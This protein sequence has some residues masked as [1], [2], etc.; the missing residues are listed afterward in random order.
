M[1]AVV[2]RVASAFAE[3]VWALV[4]TVPAG[5]VT[6]YGDVA[7]AYF[8]VRKGSRSVG[9]ALAGCPD[10]VPWWRVVRAGGALAGGVFAAEQRARLAEEGVPLT[11]TGRVDLTAAGGPFS[12]PALPSISYIADR[13][14]EYARPSNG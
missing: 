2:T 8:G 5:R 11:P 9:R 13:E 12:P 1:V 6:T 4:R 7:E 14:I 3:G 10:D